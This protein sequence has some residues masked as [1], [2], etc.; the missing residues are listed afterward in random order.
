MKYV[1]TILFLFLIGRVCA[2]ILNVPAQYS[3]IQAAITA[4]VNN[5][6]VLVATGTYTE[7]I[8]F[9]GKAI[10]VASTYFNNH[11]P[12][13][14][15]NTII[16]GTG[17]GSVVTFTSS[18]DTTSVLIGFSISGGQYNL[19]GGIT[20]R[21]ASPKLIHNSVYS[22]SGTFGAGIYLQNSHAILQNLTVCHNNGEGIRI[23][24]T[25]SPQ[26]TNCIV[27]YN[28][29]Q[30][31]NASSQALIQFCD[32]SVATAGLGNISTE[33]LFVD[34]DAGNYHLLASSSCI[35][36][37]SPFVAAD[38]DGTRPDI[39]AFIF[40]NTQSTIYT[41][42]EV[43]ITSAINSNATPMHFN[44]SIYPFN[45][46]ISSILWDFNDGNTS[47]VASP[48]YTYSMPG[49][50]SISLTVTSSTGTVFVKSKPKY[51]KIYNRITNSNLSG[52]LDRAG[53]PYYADAGILVPASQSLSID[54]GVEIYFEPNIS[55]W[56]YGE[57]MANGTENDSIS[58][59]PYIAD[60]N[61]GEFYFN[62][63]SDVSDSQLR[64]CRIVQSQ[65][66][67]IQN[68]YGDILFDHCLIIGS[69]YFGLWVQ[70]NNGN[71]TVSNCIVTE[72][73]LSTHYSGI[74][75]YPNATLTIESCQVFGNAGNAICAYVGTVSTSMINIINNQIQNTDSWPAVG[76]GP[77][78]TN[79]VIE[80]NNI[81]SGGN[82]ISIDRGATATIKNNIIHDCPYQGIYC[83][84][85]SNV[86]ILNNIVNN[87][88]WGIYCDTLST[89]ELSYIQ[90]N[91]IKTNVNDGIC[92]VQ[93]SP[94]I[95]NNTIVSNNT[96]GSANTAGVWLSYLSEPTLINN[97]LWNNHADIGYNTNAAAAAHPT[98]SYNIHQFPL[99]SQA[100]DV[101]N[102]F[103]SNPQFL[104]ESDYRLQ[105]S[106][107]AVDSGNPD[108]SLYQFL[109]TDIIGSP[110]VYDGDQS[111][112]IIIDRGCYE[113]NPT[114]VD[115][116][117][118]TPLS[119]KLSVRVYPNPFNPIL[120]LEISVSR[121]THLNI[122]IYNIKGQKVI[123]LT[124]KEQEKGQYRIVWNG[125]D[126]QS[127]KVSSGVYL[128][129]TKTS[130]GTKINKL[131]MM[132]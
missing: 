27:F 77:G 53:S 31:N 82:A 70:G 111:G 94:F 90:G 14:I 45:C 69:Y 28:T 104:S 61:W 13:V 95:S 87:N 10:T 79:V 127:R 101:G 71:V 131:I 84:A 55:F 41:D 68:S 48:T 4:S 66:A 117:E 103:I 105:S 24:T 93:S 106:S 12:D 89:Q 99:S 44:S 29:T 23:M 18:E 119:N 52:V 37:G 128:C 72:N 112:S 64:Y 65:G 50:F 97:I 132:K 26:I 2:T 98:M 126:E 15:Q 67:Q 54:S 49:Y 51:I 7:N 107:P 83:A 109:Q 76:I 62:S 108:P 110:R 120:N 11:D 100:V 73:G 130:Y 43:D 74:V 1:Y 88:A 86:K 113:Y 122:S 59:L 32:I 30:I 6:V 17:T 38:L 36:T 75:V 21:N 5:D 22:N 118:I 35:N 16:Q 96:N 20:I 3:T 57:L 47:N 80:G 34:H 42:F 40:P 39:G 25:A 19:G 121:N 85:N 91:L 129:K 56:V 115:D 124:D 9:N 123:Q 114:G 46:T 58:L 125:L 116:P 33:P 78:L 63:S 102:N 60:Q 8:N 81:V 92:L